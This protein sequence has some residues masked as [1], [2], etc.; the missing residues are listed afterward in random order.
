MLQHRRKVGPGACWLWAVLWT[1]DFALKTPLGSSVIIC[2]TSLVWWVRGGSGEPPFGSLEI[3]QRQQ[4]KGASRNPNLRGVLVKDGLG[5][6]ACMVATT[7]APHRRLLLC[8]VQRWYDQWSVFS[9]WAK[10]KLTYWSALWGP[11]VK[12]IA[13]PFVSWCASPWNEVSESQSSIPLSV[14]AGVQSQ[15]GQ[16]WPEVVT[17]L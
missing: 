8:Q 2:L 6:G 9:V 13:V 12:G 3:C 11:P 4:M 15:S 5:T 14:R 1:F 16:L 17:Q 10:V 7:P